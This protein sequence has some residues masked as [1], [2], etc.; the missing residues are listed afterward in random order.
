MSAE[1]VEVEAARTA[2]DAFLDAWNA[3][4]IEAVRATLNYPHITIG[5][6]GEVIVAATAAEF[7][8]DFARMR[9][10]EGWDRSSFDSFDLVSS[11]PNKVHCQ[12]QFSRY[13]ADGSKYGTGLV[14]YMVTNQG[15]HWGMQLRS[16]M[17]DASLLRARE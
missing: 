8:T 17:P 13:R 4:D 16:A 6:A 5:P 12:V 10:R 11:G 7:R 9:E 1:P 15:G 3:A 2:L 14:L